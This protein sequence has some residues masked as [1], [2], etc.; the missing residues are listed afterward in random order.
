MSNILWNFL[1]RLITQKKQRSDPYSSDEEFLEDVYLKILGR[2]PDGL[3]KSHYLRHLGEGDSRMSVI[4]DIIRSEE[5]INKVIKENLPMPPIRN[6]KPDHYELSYDINAQEEVLVFKIRD[7]MDFDWLEARTIENGY[8]EKP[9][10]WSLQISEDKRLMAEIAA[11]F[12]PRVVLD[13]G[14]ANGP[15]MKCLDDLGID[16]EGIDISQLAVAKAF[17][18]VK[19]R[20]HLGDIL[21]VDLTR[22]YDVILGLDIFEHLNPNKLHNYVSKINR[23]LED[24]GYLYCNIPAFGSDAIFGEIFRVYL[25]EWEEDRRQKRCFRTIHVDKHGYPENGH[26]IGADS[27]WWVKQFEDFGM[28]RETEIERALHEKHD[29]AMERIHIARKAYYVFSKQA[30]QDKNRQI[31]QSLRKEDSVPR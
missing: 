16:S 27:E 24:G 9:G 7:M 1:S 28:K 5:F 18:E 12:Q 2:E 20:I 10:V 3:G 11:A 26:I 4:L 15:V 21:D 19:A 31:I 22:K 8:Y 17:P 14:C 25:K 29:S 23:L 13:I 6:E 30:D